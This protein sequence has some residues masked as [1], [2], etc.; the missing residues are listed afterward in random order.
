MDIKKIENIMRLM[1]DYQINELEIS[2]DNLKIKLLRGNRSAQTEQPLS[3]IQPAPQP[4][5]PIQPDPQ[6]KANQTVITSPFVG[7]F[8][9]ASNP[10]AEP[11]VE[12]GDTVKKGDVLCIVEAMKLMNEIEA[13]KSGKIVEVLVE[14]G[15]PVEFDQPLIVIE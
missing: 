13:E 2:D 1:S 5:Q 6:A 8:Y 4:T 14:N 9:R 10:G 12:V 3:N 15:K 11:Y 7:T